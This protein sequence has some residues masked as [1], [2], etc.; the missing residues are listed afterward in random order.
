M[1]RII[2]VTGHRPKYF[3]NGYSE[4]HNKLLYN[5]FYNWLFKAH[6]ENTIDIYISG[7]AL[8]VDIQSTKAALDLEIPVIAGVPFK[9]Q[10]A[11][12]SVKQ[13]AEYRHLLTLVKEVVYVDELTDSQYLVKNSKPGLYNPYKL[14]LR[15]NWMIDQCTEVLALWNRNPEG[16]TYQA[17]KYA[18]SKGLTITNL[19]DK[20][21]TY[22][23]RS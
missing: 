2:T 6:S 17:V 13:Q 3:K 10:D 4:Q 1:T 7:M 18:K 23:Q 20:Y 8:G 19:W 22:N 15:N 14:L 21:E 11:R 12:W 16:G 5:L 9:N